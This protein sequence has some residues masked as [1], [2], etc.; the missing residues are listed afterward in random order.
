MMERAEIVE[1]TRAH[2]GRGR[3]ALAEFVHAPVEVASHG[4]IV[5]TADGR[6][7]IDCGGYAV[8]L[9]GH[10]PEPVVQAVV[11]QVRTHPLATRLLL[12]PKV[13]EAARALASIAPEGL[14]AV[15]FL[16][17]GAEATELGLKIARAHGKTRLITMLGGYH[18]KTTGA[19]AVTPKAEYQQRFQPLL[20]ATAVPFGDLAALEAELIAADGDAAV[21]LEPIQGEGGVVLPPAGY[22]AGVQRLCRTHEAMLIVDEIQTGLGRTGTMWAHQPEID[23]P[24]VLLVGKALSGGVVPVS[25]VLATA[26]AFRP[27]A[28]DP[29]LHS[30]TFG[31]SP[32]A[33]AA[34]VATVRA[35]VDGD[36]AARAAELGERMLAEVTEMCSRHVG[37][38]VRAVRGRGL[39]IAIEF[40]RPDL[41]GELVT[42]LLAR[43]VIVNHSLGAGSVV[44][45][46]PPA[47][48][49][50][51][52]E[53]TV[54]SALDLSLSALLSHV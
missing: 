34:V 46:S 51:D 2:L 37:R 47:V 5:E 52:Q 35:L 48:L 26:E 28:D 41:A 30:S 22:L 8:F 9:L 3:A 16:N 33:S 21:I 6:S 4:A 12:E 1:L 18:G 25:A 31:G 38:T 43:G 15:Q 50:E 40:L 53:H 49:T 44:R 17:S 14:D 7:F 19:L 42:D 11:E 23:R 32:L 10:C 27:F 24:D 36:V 45:L 29:T 20:P 13:A 54:L 39:L